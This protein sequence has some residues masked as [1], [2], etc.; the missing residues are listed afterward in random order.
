MQVLQ[1]ERFNEHLLALASRYS[2]LGNRCKHL[3]L[4]FG[5]T[6]RT[7][8]YGDRV[9]NEL[10][11]SRDHRL[12]LLEAYQLL[13]FDAFVLAV[14]NIAQLLFHP[15]AGLLD[16][17]GLRTKRGAWRRTAVYDTPGLAIIGHLHLLGVGTGGQSRHIRPL[18]KPDDPPRKQEARRCGGKGGF[19]FAP[20]H[21]LGDLHR[22]QV[23]VDLGE[24]QTL[25]G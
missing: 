11:D 6:K 19:L 9:V 13:R 18:A 5:F 1:V 4:G 7:L 21:L 17:R 10:E 15:V 12:G 23:T 2:A 16:V 24:F 14:G 8:Q 25:K 22:E 3:L 20:D